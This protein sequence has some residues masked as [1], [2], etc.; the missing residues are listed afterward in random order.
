MTTG[1][2]KKLTLS[3]GA[4]TANVVYRAKV[5][6][7]LIVGTEL[8]DVKQGESA[9]ISGCGSQK[10]INSHYLLGD[11]WA[12]GANKDW[13]HFANPILMEA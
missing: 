9:I 2:I 5:D 7:V 3:T 13:E 10:G 12:I 6:T 8:I 4:T 11:K 1:Q